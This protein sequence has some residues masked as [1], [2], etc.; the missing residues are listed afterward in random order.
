MKSLAILAAVTVGLLVSSFQASASHPRTSAASFGGHLSHVVPL[1]LPFGHR[2]TVGRVF[3]PMQTG[4]GTPTPA[5]TP[6]P[7]PG[8][9]GCAGCPDATGLIQNMVNVWAQ[10]TTAHVELLTTAE[11]TNVA[12]FTIDGIGDATCK[13]PALKL[14]VH[15]TGVLEGTAQREKTHVQFIQIKTHTWQ[16][17]VK[18]NSKWKTVK[19]QANVSIYG[20]PY[21]IDTPLICPSAGSG[22]GSSGSGQPSDVL[23][24]AATLGS[25][26]F[27]GVPVWHVQ[28]TDV[29][30]LPTGEQFNLLLDL[31][32]GQAH[33]TPYSITQTFNDT[34]DN[35]VLVNGQV[36]TKIGEKVKIKA[37][38]T[39]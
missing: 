12:K 26:T 21:P 35:V 38:K 9:V 15:A 13:G 4:S 33:Y 7:T 30:T 27:K 2:A 17:A 29:R 22:P 19:N 8:P 34:A 10:I 16:R 31:L 11:Q 6:T 25:G 23:K 20:V 24:D 36:L 14:D 37:P 39:K 28:V 32:I 3:L 1:G 5:P 18:K